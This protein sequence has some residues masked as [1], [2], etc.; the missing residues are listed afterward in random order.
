MRLAVTPGKQRTGRC[1]CGQELE[2]VSGTLTLFIIIQAS[3]L[4]QPKRCQAEANPANSWPSSTN[5]HMQPFCSD[6]LAASIL[7]VW[8]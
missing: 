2:S 3:S 1:R 6:G 5:A 7:T 4:P 8:S